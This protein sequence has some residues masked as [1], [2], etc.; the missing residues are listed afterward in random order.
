MISRSSLAF[1]LIAAASVVSVVLLIAAGILL[2]TLFTAAVERS[3]DAR[4][5]AV[6]DGLIDSVEL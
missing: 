4:L 1:R 3:L 2:S 5:Q 6:I